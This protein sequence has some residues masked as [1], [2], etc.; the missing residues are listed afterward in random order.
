MKHHDYQ[1][2]QSVA[3]TFCQKL[4]RPTPTKQEHIE[5]LQKAEQQMERSSFSMM[6]MHWNF[7]EQWIEDKQPYYLLYPS[8]IPMLSRLKL[9]RVVSESLT[10]PHGL[11][12][13]L[14][15]FPD[16]GKREVR[17]VWMCETQMNHR[18]GSGHVVRG[19]VLGIDHGEV[20]TSLMQPI[21]LIRGFPLTEESIE[22]ALEALPASWTASVGKQLD[23]QEIVTAV[24]IACTICL[25]DGNPD[26]VRPEV[27]SKDEGKA[28]QDNLD[29]L[30]DKAK[31]R[32]KFGWSV[33]KQM[34]TV[35]HYRRPHPAL[36]W[37]GKG[38]LVPKIIMRSGSIVHRETVEK[39]PTGY[40]TT[41][42]N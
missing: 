13:M 23:P 3:K 40:G 21:Y 4:G 6:L 34:E 33:G 7:N 1:T 26:L 10:L 37:T 38:R 32:G 17:S 16:D 12:S 5:H 39:V 2:I 15:R 27:L 30:V 41:D 24:R 36:V 31:R 9:E 19:L 20:D 18:A 11:K 14:V 8:I 25:L 42:E 28:S 22:D 29:R 35:P